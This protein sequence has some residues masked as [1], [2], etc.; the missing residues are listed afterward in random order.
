VAGLGDGGEE[1][2]RSNSEER[3]KDAS[4]PAQLTT[5]DRDGGGVVEAVCGGSVNHGLSTSRV[6]RGGGRCKDADQN[7]DLPPLA[8]VA[9]PVGRGGGNDQLEL[10]DRVPREGGRGGAGAR[11]AGWRG[12]R[13]HAPTTAEHHHRRRPDQREKK[14]M[15]AIVVGRAKSRRGPRRDL[16]P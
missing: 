10:L 9:Q 7:P 1:A 4:R 3:I 6:G 12:R 8:L 5:R 16:W 14:E 15:V 11:G 2:E 13:R